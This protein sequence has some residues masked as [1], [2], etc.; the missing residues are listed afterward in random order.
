[1]SLIGLLAIVAGILLL[2]VLIAGV[3]KYR[4]VRKELRRGGDDIVLPPQK[5]DVFNDPAYEQWSED[6]TLG[7]Q[8]VTR[9]EAGQLHVWFPTKREGEA[10]R[11]RWLS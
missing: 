1:M 11:S 2:H 10:F 5:E 9:D 4:A 3:L 7:S 8:V 6:N